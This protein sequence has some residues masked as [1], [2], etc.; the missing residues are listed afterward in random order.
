MVLIQNKHKKF[1]KIK[2]DFQWG[3]RDMQISSWKYL[4]NTIQRNED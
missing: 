3:I 2:F 1:L 4:Q